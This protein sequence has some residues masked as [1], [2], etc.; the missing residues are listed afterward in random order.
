MAAYS[1]ERAASSASAGRLSL[2]H[3]EVAGAGTPRWTRAAG[4]VDRWRVRRRPRWP[5]PGRS[6][7][8][9]PG[10]RSPRPGSA[11]G[12]SAGPPATA[13]AAPITAASRWRAPGVIGIGC[14][15]GAQLRQGG[16]GGRVLRPAARPSRP[17]SSSGVRRSAGGRHGRTDHSRPAASRRRRAPAARRRAAASPGM[18]GLV[19]LCRLPVPTAVNTI[20]AGPGVTCR[21]AR[22]GRRRS[23]ALR[24]AQPPRRDAAAGGVPA[25]R[26]SDQR[27]GSTRE[28]VRR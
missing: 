17:E 13:A 19:A 3:L 11:A 16:G 4:P 22:P 10:R 24:S 2:D 14:Q 20:R 18:S 7:R 8:R 27:P 9:R 21:C 12:P 26:D 15:R 6:S 5:R 28:R 23:G 1:A 25:W